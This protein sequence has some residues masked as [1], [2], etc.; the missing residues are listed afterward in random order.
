MALGLGVPEHSVGPVTTDESLTRSD[1]N[2]IL[3]RK[4]RILL[5]VALG[6]AIVLLGLVLEDDDLVAL[7]PGP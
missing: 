2:D 6:P 1:P 7:D 3:D 4:E 5:P